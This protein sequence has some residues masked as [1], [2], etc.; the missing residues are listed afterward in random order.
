MGHVDD[1]TARPKRAITDKHRERILARDMHRCQ[2]PWCRSTQY[3]DVHHVIHRADGGDNADS[4]LTTLCRGHHRLHHANYLDITGLAPHGLT[5]QRVN[6]EERS[7]P[8]G[9]NDVR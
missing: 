8:R 6:D 1:P 2:V 5:F 3:L 7:R 9:R 4:N